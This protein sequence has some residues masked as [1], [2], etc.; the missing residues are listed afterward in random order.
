MNIKDLILD[1]YP[2]SKTAKDIK[3]AK[4]I[5]GRF[6][7]IELED[8]SSSFYEVSDDKLYVYKRTE[9]TSIS[10]YKKWVQIF[11]ETKLNDLL[12]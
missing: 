4:L 10:D 3:S 12:S 1:H 11:R 5:D 6:I 7:I 9:V 2:S 8:G